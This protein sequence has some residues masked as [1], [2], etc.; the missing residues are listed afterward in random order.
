MKTHLYFTFGPVQTFVAQARRTRDLYAG[1]FLL[2][3]L[4]LAAMAKA[5][6]TGEAT[7]RKVILPDYSALEKLMERKTE[8]AIAPNR[9]IAKFADDATAAEAGRQ[10]GKALEDKWKRI[11][12]NI[13]TCFLA[14]VA[15]QGNDTRAIWDR[16]V[17]NFWEIAWAVG[18]KA[19]TDLLDRRKNWHT[20]RTTTRTTTEGGD[21]C[22]LMGQWQELSGFI[23][24]KGDTR[25]DAFWEAVRNQRNVNELDLETDERLCAIAFVKRFFPL[26]SEKTIG[27]KLDMQNWPS[28]V[29]IAAVPWMRKIAKIGEVKPKVHDDA[30]AYAEEVRHEPG[31]ILRSARR[32]AALRSFPPAIAD[33]ALLSGNFLNHTALKNERGTPLNDNDPR[34]RLLLMKALRVFEEKEASD[35]HAGN[36]YALLLMDGDSMGRII[37]E[38][39]AEKVTSALTC[40][41]S[42][43]PQLI[44]N[45]RHSG[46]CIYAGGDD[47]LAMLP[48]DCALAAVAAIHDN[49]RQAFSLAGIENATISAGLVFAHYHCAFSRV[50]KYAHDLLHDV[51]KDGAGRDALAIGVLKPGGKTCQWVAKFGDFIDG[52]SNC[53]APLVEAYQSHGRGESGGLSASFLYNLRERFGQILEIPHGDPAAKCPLAF[54]RD[55][56][57]SLFV[58]EYLVGKRAEN[59]SAAARQLESANDL[60]I[61]LLAVCQPARSGFTT[62]R[63]SLDGARL[64]KFLA[65]DGKEGAE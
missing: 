44:E 20:P 26:V 50:L 1:S 24:Q 9:F 23:R 37:R 19:E 45:D 12:E 33:F 18:S 58:A 3:H 49:Y 61:Q 54:D 48:L 38:K 52:E 60:M 40:F 51:A 42:N 21:H 7:E 34:R 64:V 22:T 5:E 4:S 55:A 11:A 2:S 6:A 16:Q 10:A 13:W 28:T 65:L 63:L 53:F 56:L 27:V 57:L 8:H 35:D 47:L 17:S 43:V 36:F 15:A 62:A 41:A 31:A 14:P 25:Q 39:G 32:L 30:K 59:T 46:V 29:S